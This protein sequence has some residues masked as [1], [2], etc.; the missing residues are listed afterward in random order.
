MN[1][2]ALVFALGSAAFT[3]AVT[4]FAQVIIRGTESTDNST[5]HSEVN[6]TTSDRNIVPL[7]KESTET[8]VDSTTQRSETV[9]RARLNDGS[10]FEWQRSTATKKELSPDKSVNSTDVVEK[11]RQ[12]QERLSR[13]TDETVN[14]SPSGETAETKVYTR[15]GSGQLVLDRVVDANTV[16]GADGTANTTRLEKVAD[17]N[18]NLVMRTQQEEVAVERGPNE[19]VVTS[20]TMSPDHLTGKLAVTAEETTSIT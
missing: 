14:K 4:T 9:T 10:Y 2:R 13:H 8:K 12:G 18:G 3:V 16:K 5:T 1:T 7:I 11:D 19:K 15:N 6:I 20:R 17:V